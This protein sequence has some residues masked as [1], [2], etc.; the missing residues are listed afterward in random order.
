M[1][2][3]IL[4]LVALCTLIAC[5]KKTPQEAVLDLADEQC[6]CGRTFADRLTERNEVILERAA[7]GL[8]RDAQGYQQLVAAVV[9]EFDLELCGLKYTRKVDS[10]LDYLPTRLV[11]GSRKIALEAHHK[12]LKECENA[13][14]EPDP[15]KLAHNARVAKE[16][17]AL[18]LWRTKSNDL[19]SALKQT[20]YANW[21]V[22]SLTKEMERK[23]GH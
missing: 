22:D 23:Y 4:Y 10:V 12:R 16:A 2:T 3:S 11:D 6:E 14:P 17:T 9:K 8:G 15:E 7:K 1:K 20:A 5:G 13:R 19:A 18:A 21:D